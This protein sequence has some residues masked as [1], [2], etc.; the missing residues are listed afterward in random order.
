MRCHDDRRMAKRRRF[1]VRSHCS[2]C[3]STFYPKQ[4]T[5]LRNQSSCCTFVHKHLPSCKKPSFFEMRAQQRVLGL[6][7]LFCLP[8]CQVK[9]SRLLHQ[10]S[11]IFSLVKTWHVTKNAPK[12]T[13]PGSLFFAASLSFATLC[14]VLADYLKIQLNRLDNQQSRSG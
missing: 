5:I 2:I 8:V 12:S 4:L 9:F 13:S 14:L 3:S 6:P 7:F 10:S 11:G 1:A